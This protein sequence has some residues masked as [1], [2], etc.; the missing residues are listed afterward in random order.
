MGNLSPSQQ[1]LVYLHVNLKN[2]I[3]IVRGNPANVLVNANRIFFHQYI[4]SCTDESSLAP[5]AEERMSVLI[6]AEASRWS[7]FMYTYTSGHL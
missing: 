6:E 1:A 3:E 5:A 7:E 4:F 2:R